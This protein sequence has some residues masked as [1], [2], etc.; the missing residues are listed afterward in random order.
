MTP[1][2]LHS[3]GL[4]VGGKMKVKNLNKVLIF[5]IL[6]YLLTCVLDKIKDVISVVR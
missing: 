1:P 5:I 6:I 4:K 3:G 2:I